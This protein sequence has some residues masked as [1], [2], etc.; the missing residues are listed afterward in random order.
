M[1]KF[2]MWGSLCILS[3]GKLEWQSLRIPYAHDV[4]D[5]MML[6]VYDM[7]FCRCGKTYCTL[8]VDIRVHTL[9]GVGTSAMHPE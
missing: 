9:A 1:L 7:A 2:E 3:F 4:A 5:D 8:Y 6:H